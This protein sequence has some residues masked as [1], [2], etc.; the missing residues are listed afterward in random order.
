[1]S[2]NTTK[3]TAEK[4]WMDGKLLN[5]DEAQIHVLTH[6]LHYGLGVFEGIR[7]YRAQ[8]NRLAVF[9]LTEHMRRFVE[10]AHICQLNMPYTQKQLET[11]C[12]ELL[13]SQSETLKDMVYIRPVAFMGDGSMGL[14]AI[15]PTRV[16]IIAWA[17][18]S[19]LGEEGLSKGI[20]AKVSSYGR[21]HVN[22]AMSKAK[23][24]GHYVNSILAKREAVLS[25][26]DESIFLDTQGYVAEASAENIFVVD[27]H[28]TVKT[29]PLSLAILDGITR[30]SAIQILRNDMG[31]KVEEVAFT[32]DELYVAKEVF[33]TGTAAEVTP[34]REVDGRQIGPGTVGPK[35]KE[36][37]ERYLKAVRG[38]YPQYE[39]WLSYV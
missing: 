9:R 3:A 39:N 32:R 23:V 18:G 36:L 13:R 6:G 37:Q 29:P 28:G 34:I 21:L 35:A 7:A 17:W 30:E 38:H 1:M 31:C 27:R 25:G 19:Y 12:L 33:I 26:V 10:S 14:A 8:N 24:N 22:T 16:A 2:T 20:R 4:I 15:N 11:A 5:W